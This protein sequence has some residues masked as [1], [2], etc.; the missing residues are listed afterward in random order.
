M[1]RELAL[2][3]LILVFALPAVSGPAAGALQASATPKA[4][5]P[6]ADLNA[7]VAAGSSG[8]LTYHDASNRSGYTGS[9]P[10]IGTPYVSWS[11]RVGGPVFAEPLYYDGETYVATENDS[12]YALSSTSGAVSW[13]V[14]LA[15][16]ALSHS[17]TY[18]CDGGSPSITPLIGIT[19][20]PVIDPSTS[21]LYVVAL[22]AG[23]GFTLFAIDT[24]SGQV[25][26]SSPVTASGFVFT[27]EEQR[28]AL[29]LADGFVYVPFGSYSWSCTPAFGWLI[30]ISADGNGT[31]YSFRVDT[32][33]EGDVWEPEGVTVDSAGFLYVATGNSY[34]NATYNYAD[35]VLK[36]TPQ[37]RMVG[38][39]APSDWA[40][41]GPADLDQDTTGVT[42]LPG[43]LAFSIGKSGVGFL[44]N[45]SDL[46]GVGGQL[47]SVAVCRTPA[48][49]WPYGAW[50]STSY[51]D[52]V[53][54]VPCN[55][56]LVALSLH[57]GSS[58][59]FT[60]LW[61]YTG[62]YAGP[63]II[64]AGAVWTV[65]IPGGTLYALSPATGAVLYETA[66]SAVE[67]FTTP[68]AGG[69]F[70]YVAAN[71]TIYAISPSSSSSTTSS[72]TVASQDTA[73][74]TITG[75]YVTLYDSSMRT[76]GTGFTP[77]DFTLDDGQTYA[78][79]ADGYGGCA[80][81][82]WADTGSTSSQ[83][84]ISISEDAQITA[85]Y[86]C[87]TTSSVTVD[88]VNQDGAAITGY[89]TVLYGSGGSQLGEGFTPST[90][91]T[92]AGE[93][94]GVKT[95]SY[96]SCAFV[97]WS[98]GVTSDPRSF[99]ATPAASAF[100][101]VY[102]CSTASSV[103]VD[104]VNQDGQTISG[105]RTALYG[106]DGSVVAQGFTPTAFTTTVGQA[107]QMGA[108]SYGSCAF[109]RWSDGV[110]SDPRPFTASGSAR[111]F[112][113]VYDCTAPAAPGIDVGSAAH[114]GPSVVPA[115]P[116]PGAT[117]GAPGVADAASSPPPLPPRTDLPG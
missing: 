101:A 102:D 103:T 14:H 94:Y 56:G 95:E 4:S 48:Q 41:N 42:L 13:S 79:Q 86:D 35:S 85:V 17:P 55:T 51:Y 44:L 58:P 19:G 110:T 46:G 90:F 108:E 26:W 82:H 11:S 92:S 104:S 64:A 45:A 5:G 117:G 34:Y 47:Y 3:S 61:N 16:P 32:Q 99:T 21:T 67:H 8:W 18:S 113:A 70:V 12:V 15:T 49:G 10:E 63:A 7:A 69:G 80:F 73:G 106:A 1:G 27:G 83:R 37:L 109:V 39:F 40:H 38:Y 84:T 20:T 100:T 25:R 114:V 53:I 28:G 115:F 29:A 97:R 89:R 74:G 111:S 116:S 93:T 91:T 50:G 59:S 107:Y 72:L 105:Y 66:L 30:G 54:Y 68:S 33:S 2:V 23:A 31:S 57:G 88:S 60:A 71:E 77:A 98:D 75:Y 78:V 76:V 65:A 96:G 22:N 24:A 52:G 9:L 62:I 36:F 87:S 43:N 112:T 81:D 6:A